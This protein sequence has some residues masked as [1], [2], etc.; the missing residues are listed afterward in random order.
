MKEMRP[1][2]N[3]MGRISRGELLEPVGDWYSLQYMLEH[4]SVAD[5]AN[6]LDQH[7]IFVLD[8]F[9][10]P[11]QASDGSELD[12]NSR[13]YALSLLADRYAELQ[14]PGPVYSWKEERWDTEPHPTQRFGWPK[15]GILV[16]S[17]TESDL[18]DFSALKDDESWTNRRPEEFIAEKRMAGSFKAA[19]DLHNVSRQRYTEVYKRLVGSE[20]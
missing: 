16:I 2:V 5:L 1:L 19:A 9:G 3:L 15:S 20:Q 10:R 12:Q 4:L 14:S 11:C 6:L 17:S 13:A 18:S 8:S 7:G